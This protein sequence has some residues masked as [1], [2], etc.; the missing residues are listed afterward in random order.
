MMNDRTWDRLSGLLIGAAIGVVAGI[1]LAPSAGT[2]TRETIKQF[3]AWLESKLHA[4]D[5]AA[6][7]HYET[8]APYARLAVPA[9]GQEHFAPLFYAMGAGSRPESVE[10]LHQGWMWDVMTNS[11]YAFR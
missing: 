5:L 10:T 8:E 3:E 6:L 4:W 9:N 1:L 7:F 11:V 2:D